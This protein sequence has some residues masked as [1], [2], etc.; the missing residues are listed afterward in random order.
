MHGK[1]NDADSEMEELQLQGRMR[2]I[3]QK[4]IVLSGKGGVGKS[5]VAANLAVS[6]ALKGKKTGLLDVDLHGPS[7]PGLLGIKDK[8]ILT[9]ANGNITPLDVSENL[10]VVSVGLLLD[11]H[12]DAV[13]WRGPMKYGVIRQFLKDVEWG[14]LD[15]LVIDSPPGTGDEPLSVAQLVGF[16]SAAVIVTTPQMIAIDDVRRGISFCEKLDI[17]V[18]GIIENMSGFSCPHCNELSNLFGSGGG[19]KLAE[20]CKVPFLGKIPITPEIASGGD[21]GQTFVKEYSQTAAA[22]AFDKIVDSLISKTEKNDNQIKETKQMKIAIPTAAKK[23]CMHFGHCEEFAL[24]DVDSTAKKILK[25]EY[26]VPPPHEPGL[27]PKWLHEKGANV[28]VAGGMG[29]R[30]Q[31]LFAEN[32]IIVVTGAIG[33]APEDIALAYLNKTLQTG[34]NTCDH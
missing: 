2:S 3:K 34:S 32:N 10:K 28:I 29:Q 24:I 33:E 4:F 18:A 16:N 1:E 7:I 27:L 15:Y 22:K 23:L 12:K 13:I 26:V 25:T 11:S 19:E 17:P 14:D 30:A 8:R 31:N 5:T 6:L 9:D 20:E 21:K